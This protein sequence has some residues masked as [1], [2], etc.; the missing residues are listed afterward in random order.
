M[1]PLLS[2]NMIVSLLCIHRWEDGQRMRIRT[3]GYWTR[4]AQAVF[5]QNELQDIKGEMLK[6]QEGEEARNN[7]DIYFTL[8]AMNE[9]RLYLTIDPLKF[10]LTN[11]HLRSRMKNE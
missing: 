9:L 1:I 10:F 4:K 6:E 7:S 2:W 3:K 8:K 11:D 5:V